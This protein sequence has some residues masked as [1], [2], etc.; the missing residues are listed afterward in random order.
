M[1]EESF[2][3]DQD[4]LLFV[5]T[6]GHNTEWEKLYSRLCY[7]KSILG[8]RKKKKRLLPLLPRIGLVKYNT[9]K[10]KGEMNEYILKPRCLVRGKLR[11]RKNGCKV[12]GTRQMGV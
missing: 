8:T 9:D 7:F 1:K 3:R 10:I 2:I 11:R 5:T 12:L 6:S 4:D